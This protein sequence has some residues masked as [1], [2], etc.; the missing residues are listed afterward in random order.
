MADPAGIDAYVKFTAPLLGF[1]FD[2]E[3]EAAVVAAFA[4]ICRI[5]G[6]ALNYPLARLAEPAP[7][8][9]PPFFIAAAVP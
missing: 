5:A 6:P 7:V 2:A 3:R 8:F 9:T 4:L 1:S